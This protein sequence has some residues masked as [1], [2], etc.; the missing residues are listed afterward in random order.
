MR[1]ARD[2][3]SAGPAVSPLPDGL[4]TAAARVYAD[5]FVDDP[6]WRSVGPDGRRR[7]WRYVRRICGA[8]VRVARRLGGTV[9]ATFDDGAPS[10]VLV[11]Y[12]PEGRP[13]SW[14]MTVAQAPGAAL[15]GPVVVARSLVADGVLGGGHP[16]EPH[17]YVSLLAVSPAL[18]RGGRGRALLGD[19]LRWAD[20]LGVPAYLDT[21]NPDNL[22]YY[23]SFGFALTGEARLPRGAP[24]WYLLR[25]ARGA[26]AR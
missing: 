12:P 13:A 19:V 7:R 6:G 1:S 8:E 24:L 9:L 26:T 14:R 3:G 18:Q 4:R 20:E 25:P 22:P 16:D 17:L 2:A 15:A 21:A 10:G 23:R 11:F 5:A